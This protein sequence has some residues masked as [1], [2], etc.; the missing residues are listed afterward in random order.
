M[1]DDTDHNKSM[2]TNKCDEN[3]NPK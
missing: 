2:N 3:H 1:E